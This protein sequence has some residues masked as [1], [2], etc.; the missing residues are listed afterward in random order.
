MKY[1]CVYLAS[2]VE[3]LL[4]SGEKRYDMLISSIKNTSQ[5]F[6]DID[7]IIFH[8]DFSEKEENEIRKVHLKSSFHKLDFERKDLD[9]KNFSRPKGYM[10]MCRF[11]S[12]ELQQFLIEH[13]Y[14]GY[15]RFDDDSFFIEPYISKS[16]FENNM[17]NS[18][19]IFRTLFFDG[20]S[21]H[22]NGKPMQ[23]LYD[24]TISFLKTE[25][26]SVNK[27]FLTYLYK[28]RVITNDGMYSGL[29]PY[30]NFHFLDLNVWK[31]PLIQKYVNS[32][33][34]NNGCLMNFWMDANIHCM[35]IFILYPLINAK[36]TTMTNFGYR[37]NR[38][39][40]IINSLGFKYNNDCSF[41]PIE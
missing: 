39:F 19:Y 25:G 13:N 11:F 20:Q 21:K 41:Y 38:H 2:P 32:V 15:I 22:N 5:I 7:F 6:T 28:N 18:A 35:I 3:S 10:L 17:K 12:G 34:E 4:S 33:L 29:A 30:N 37:H 9:F 14:D 23:T 24:Y 8:E 27:D 1:C 40:S 26:I 31:H 36:V 16:E